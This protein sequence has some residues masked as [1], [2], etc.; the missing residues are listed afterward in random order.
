[1]QTTFGNIPIKF[2]VQQDTDKSFFAVASVFIGQEE[3]FLNAWGRTE[4][5]LYEDMNNA[6]R[7]NSAIFGVQLLPNVDNEY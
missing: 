3:L 7:H 6:C 1:M 2:L 4:A 5:E